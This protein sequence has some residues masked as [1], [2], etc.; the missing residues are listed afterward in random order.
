[1]KLKMNK[2]YKNQQSKIIK[3][4]LWKDQSNSKSENGLDSG[5]NKTGLN[6]QP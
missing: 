2:Q 4:R 1:M 3:E 5:F 6:D